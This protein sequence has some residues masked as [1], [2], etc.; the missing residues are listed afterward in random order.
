MAHFQ[1]GDQPIPG[2]TLLTFLGEGGFGEVWKAQNP[3][4][5]EIALKIVDIQGKQG[6]REVL[7]IRQLRNIRHPNLIPIF[8]FWLKDQEGNV[9]EN[10]AADSMS[11]FLLDGDY[12]FFL[13]MGLGD[14]NL[15]ERLKECQKDSLPGIP[16]E[17][18]IQ[19]MEEAARALDFLNTPQ[20][21]MAEG[22]EKSSIEHCDIKPGNMMLVGGSVQLCDFG[23]ARVLQHGVKH[24][25]SASFSHHYVAPELL[26]REQGP[27]RGTDQYSLAIS[28]AE[29]RTGRLPFRD[30][31]FAPAILTAH[32]EGNLDFSYLPQRE[33]TILRKATAMKPADRFPTVKAFVDAL[34][35]ALGMSSRL[36]RPSLLGLK[37]PLRPGA[38]IVPGFKLEELI[39]RGSFGEVWRAAAPGGLKKALKIIRNLDMASGRQ[40]M[41]GLDLITQVRH[42]HLMTIE[43]FFLLDEGGEVIPDDSR[44]GP[45]APKADT[46]VIVSELADGHLGARMREVHSESGT[47]IPPA[48]LLPYMQ[49]VAAA[50]DRLNQN[51]DIIHRDVKPE[52]ILLVAG[53][54]KLADFGLAKALEGTSA[55]VH[56]K[57]IGMTPAYAAPELCQNRIEKTTDQYSL[58]LTYYHL[59]T[60]QL[61]TGS[62]TDLSELIQAHLRGHLHFD[63][64]TPAEQEVLR[65][66]SAPRAGD[67]YPSCTAFVNALTATLSGIHAA[68]PTL[69]DLPTPHRATQVSKLVPIPTNAPTLKTDPPPE[70][71][72]S[73]G[74]T[75]AESHFWPSTTRR[76]PR[77]RHR[78]AV[79]LVVA[80]LALTGLGIALFVFT[81]G[82]T[83]ASLLAGI[84][85]LISRKEYPGALEPLRELAKRMSPQ[86]PQD[87]QE[88]ALITTAN[89][90]RHAQQVDPADRERFRHAYGKMADDHFNSVGEQLRRTP[91]SINW[92][93]SKAI[94]SL[95]TPNHPWL[96]AFQLVDVLRRPPGP[97]LQE[98]LKRIEQLPPDA[99]GTFGVYLQGAAAAHAGD[100]PK[101][102]TYFVKLSPDDPN[103]DG[104]VQRT[105]IVD[106]LKASYAKHRQ[107]L[108]EEKD[109]RQLLNDPKRFEAVNGAY[110]VLA[111][112]TTAPTSVEDRVIRFLVLSFG[113]IA[114]DQYA[115]I[116]DHFQHSENLL[117]TLSRPVQL[118]VLARFITL[119]DT[120]DALIL[121]PYVQKFLSIARS[122]EFTIPDRELLTYLH[123]WVERIHGRIK[124]SPDRRLPA[125]HEQAADLCAARGRILIQNASES[126]AIEKGGLT[127]TLADFELAHELAP[128]LTNHAWKLLIQQ[129]LG[130]P[131]WKSQLATF[132]A[133]AASPPEKALAALLDGWNRYESRQAAPTT[134][135]WKQA[136]DQAIKRFA[137]A[138]TVMQGDA[139]LAGYPLNLARAGRALAQAELATLQ[140]P[141]ADEEQR[142]KLRESLKEA[143]ALARTVVAD[144]RA[145][146][147]WAHAQLALGEALDGLTTLF[148][149]D[150]SKDVIDALT[151][152]ANRWQGSS[153]RARPL[154]SLARLLLRSP[155]SNN[156]TQAETHLNTALSL[157]QDG[158]VACE[159]NYW[160]ARFYEQQRRIDAAQL[161]FAKAAKLPGMPFYRDAARCA[162][163]AMLLEV[164]LT[165]PYAKNAADRLQKIE[166]EL[167]LLS[168]V[169]PRLKDD[170]LALAVR[171]QQHLGSLHLTLARLEPERHDAHLRDATRRR[172]ELTKDQSELARFYAARLSAQIDFA[173]ENDASALRDTDL[174]GQFEATLKQLNKSSHVARA[175]VDLADTRFEIIYDGFQKLAGEAAAN[176]RHADRLLSALDKNSSEYAI[177]AGHAGL[178]RYVHLRDT[179]RQIE[180]NKP[181]DLTQGELNALRRQAVKQF[182]DAV[183][184]HPRYRCAWKWYFALCQLSP[185]QAKKEEYAV[186]CREALKLHSEGNGESLLPGIEEGLKRAVQAGKP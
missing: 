39:G 4:R 168:S 164:P 47:G 130:R 10:A 156:L 108:L 181:V 150:H 97:E 119:N 103:V 148:Q 122:P 33:Q 153:R 46:L 124:Q 142:Q 7:A 126:W 42:P 67:R 171:S 86:T 26:K 83:D 18:L 179:A 54:A 52:N 120:P 11:G 116:N 167:P 51:H 145:G 3:H 121:I 8:G 50:L 62:T 175:I 105:I 87:I 169:D 76:R 89:Y 174:G 113:K 81:R 79:A 19:Y 41:R 159:A 91:A 176:I 160:L 63:G 78:A 172:D 99:L 185:E 30:L 166:T 22:R 154:T 58:A 110:S 137:D 55:L 27:T 104:A 94:A 15:N 178:L 45:D 163:V 93:Q 157:I 68:T 66:A 149:E 61:A 101:A 77:R 165:A 16:L 65:K 115:S 141:P 127:K 82:E 57:S 90:L 31:S 139:D 53:V 88:G 73:T 155:D 131:E 14:K 109:W 23:L 21:T 114:P 183:T 184:L 177:M 125:F 161:T 138:A 84:D 59:R 118:A 173:Q 117:Q 13:A 133:A 36:T 158:P 182:E 92:D 20:H 12:Q 132:T 75:V 152:A 80:V 151:H 85:Q 44:S 95:A 9:L 96:L 32:L 186:K 71:P 24:Q 146:P 38:E 60:G 111:R 17:E 28:Y 107:A 123:G 74:A 180:E 40:E 35:D 106:T 37:G 34:K 134:A 69:Q 5:I 147:A 98:A 112:W 135:E 70:T 64:I 2:H 129:E 48:E 170:A 1:A 43:S 162:T 25:H 56:T 49:Q 140:D 100:Q 102:L 6:L 144:S 143:E 29:L 136:L 128:S 72:R